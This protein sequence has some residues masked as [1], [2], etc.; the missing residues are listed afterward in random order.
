MAMCEAFP[1]TS[2][3]AS[4]ILPTMSGVSLEPGTVFAERYIIEAQLGGGAAGV[5]F[6]ALHAD[7]KQR[8][9]IKWLRDSAPI[10]VERMVREARAALA[11]HSEHIVRVMDVG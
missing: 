7:L 2:G 9:A 4:T 8:V 11:L 5:V 10:G 6:S 3:S 1:A